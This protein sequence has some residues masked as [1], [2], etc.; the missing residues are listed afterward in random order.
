[1]AIL[2]RL[3]QSQLRRKAEALFANQIA[4]I[5]M[6][7]YPE[8]RRTLSMEETHAASAVPLALTPPGMS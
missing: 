6:N 4:P 2:N 1:M 8:D 5:A 3:S 7:Q